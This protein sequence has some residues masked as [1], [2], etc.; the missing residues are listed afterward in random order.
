[1]SK[2]FRKIAFV[3]I[4]VA[5]TAVLYWVFFADSRSKQDVLEYSLNLL[6]KKL[7]AMMPDTS[8]TRSVASLYGDFVRRAKNKEVAPEKVESVAATI[9]NLSN[10]DTVISPKEMEA[11]I[12]LSLAGPLDLDQVLPEHIEPLKSQQSLTS[13]TIRK[14]QSQLKSAIPSDQWR[15]IG[16]RIRS[17]NQ[18]NEEYRRAIRKHRHPGEMPQF[19]FQFHAHDGLRIAIDST[20]KHQLE[21]REFRELHKRIR[22]LEKQRIIIW[23]R[24]V[25]QKII[26][27][28]EQMRKEL[29]SLQQ[30][31]ELENLKQLKELEALK[32]LSDPRFIEALQS[33]EQLK[34]LKSLESLQALDSLSSSLFLLDSMLLKRYQF[35]IDSLS[36]STR[37][38]RSIGRR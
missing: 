32:S 35:L 29:E 10:L 6:G 22:E 20:G 36:D 16:E 31:K 27:D 30:L 38:R 37:Q 12:Q 26:Q 17:A 23:Q 25:H 18:F 21:Q 28:F 34:A 1:M 8:D 4:T 9:L 7:L 33:L 3:L 19:Q 11:I 13:D 5:L 14:P 15:I 2:A 24:D